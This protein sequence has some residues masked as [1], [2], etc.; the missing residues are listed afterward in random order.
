MLVLT[1]RS[2]QSIVIGKDIV[3]TVLEVR[4]DQVRI[5][6]SA[7]RDVDVHRE[8]VFLE[9]QETTDGPINRYE[10]RGRIEL[11]GEAVDIR[12]VHHLAGTKLPT[13]TPIGYVFE[14]RGRPVGAVELNG[15]PALVVEPG[16]S[17]QLERTLTLAALAAM[18]S[19]ALPREYVTELAAATPRPMPTSMASW[20]APM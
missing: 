15:R 14:Q 12:S 17:P 13:S 1:R 5:G 20:S 6:V 7:P 11:D 10:R 4:G 19:R 3:V 16:A 2:S 18:A 9:L 8:E